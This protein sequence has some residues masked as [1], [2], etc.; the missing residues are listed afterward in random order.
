MLN[1]NFDF[2]RWDIVM[3]VAVSLMG[4]A[5]AYLRR[6]KWKVLVLSLPVPFTVATLSLGQNVAATH[7]LGLCFMILYTFGVRALYVLLGLPIVL[8]IGIAAGAYATLGVLLAGVVPNTELA[9]WT[10]SAALFVSLLVL[11]RFMSYRSEPGHRTPLPV[12]IK[13]PVIAGIVLMLIV[14]KKMLQGFMTM[15]PMVGLIGAYE[16]RHFLWTICRALP[17]ASLC[18]LPMMAVIHVTQPYVGLGAALAFGWVIYLSLMSPVMMRQWRL[19]DRA[20]VKGS[21]CC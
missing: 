6:P 13:L 19:I 18:M 17:A 12:W 4:T 10:L 7:V 15:F 1:L 3:L 14:S 11:L 20:N 16:S 9:F 5:M 2:N 21:F 8:S